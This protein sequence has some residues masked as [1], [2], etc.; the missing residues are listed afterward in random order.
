MAMHLLKISRSHK[1]SR[2]P[3][4]ITMEGSFRSL[5]A[6]FLFNKNKSGDD[7]V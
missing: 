6:P 7:M 4:S 2:V 3:L 5:L 1:G